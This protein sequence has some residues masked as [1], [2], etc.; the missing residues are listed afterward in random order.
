MKSRAEDVID[1]LQ[2]Q[3][4][5]MRL[6]ARA[7]E[8][9]EACTKDA[10]FLYWLIQC[11][12]DPMPP[13]T[14]TVSLDF[15]TR[16]RLSAVHADLGERGSRFIHRLAAGDEVPL[17]WVKA[18]AEELQTLLD[19][20]GP[21]AGSPLGPR[22]EQAEDGSLL[23]VGAV[24]PETALDYAYTKIREFVRYLSRV[25]EIEENG[26]FQIGP[27][28]DSV[29]CLW[30][31]STLACSLATQMSSRRLD[32]S[33]LESTADGIQRGVVPMG[34]GIATLHGP[35]ADIMRKAMFAVILNDFSS[36]TLPRS[37]VEVLAQIVD[38]PLPPLPQRL[39]A[40]VARRRTAKNTK[41]SQDKERAAK[42][43]VCERTI[44][45]YRREA[46]AKG[47]ENPTF[48]DIERISQNRKKKQETTW[49]TKKRP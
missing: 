1:L 28:S 41:S 17:P 10:Q 30:E 48:R 49:K 42:L 46:R 38:E 22:I 13:T 7:D 43:G 19:A 25:C 31:D 39:A 34:R 12:P 45:S 14:E 9:R 8:L 2:S 4:G 21:S 24:T 6:R 35:T 26:D 36:D 44:Q 20:T 5:M 23:I 11:L 3:A 15:L 27:Y 33:Y 29:R 37:K 32:T 47:I 18:A 16:R 40:P